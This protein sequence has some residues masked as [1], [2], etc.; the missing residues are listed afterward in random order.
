MLNGY[1]LLVV[2]G[3]DI[4]TPTNA[5]DP[6][7]YFQTA[8]DSKGY[9]LFHL[10]T[11]YNLLDKRYV[12]AIIQPCRMFNEHRALCNMVDRVSD[13]KKVIIIADR[14]YEGYNTIAHIEKKGWNYL[15]RVK[16]QQRYCCSIIVAR[17]RRI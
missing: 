4:H 13:R 12:D 14:G 5:N 8:P 9:N 2:D 10:N 3:S 16:K 6:D 11:L 1:E 7:S 15:I 17:G